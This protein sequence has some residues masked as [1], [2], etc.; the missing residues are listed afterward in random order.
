MNKIL[1]EITL[2]LTNYCYLNCLHCS[3]SSSPHCNNQIDVINAKRI[4]NE[5]KS[6]NISKISFGGGEPTAH[7]NFIEILSYATDLNIPVEVFSCGILIRNERLL[8][9]SNDIISNA[10][11]NPKVKYIFSI[12]GAT[13]NVH[14]EIAQKKGS[15]N[16]LIQTLNLFK[17]AEISFQLNFV[18]MIKNHHHLRDIIKLAATF[19]IKKISILRFV[20]QGRGES[21]KH[22]LQL[23]QDQENYFINTLRKNRLYDSMELR[24]G[25][26]F[27]E[28]IKENNI[29]CRAGFQ[30]LVIQA[31][32]NV[33]PCEVFKHKNRCKWGLSVFEKSLE[34][35]LCNKAIENLHHKLK[36]HN[37]MKCPIHNPTRTNNKSIKCYAFSNN[38]V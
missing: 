38:T 2:E 6:L 8:P 31:D 34:E 11:N 9:L 7:P 10:E 13:E 3:S 4:I 36:Q 23:S 37:C 16:T 30:K 26:P 32:G 24:T 5:A 21:N 28:I 1:D 25:S 27:N 12:H 33:I 29:P 20:P 19:N 14:D 17:N 35:I 22:D 15:F 18:P